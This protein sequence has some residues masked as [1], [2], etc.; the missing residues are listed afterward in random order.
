M[1]QANLQEIDIAVRKGGRKIRN[2]RYS[3]DTTLFAESKEALLQLVTNVKEK[4]A[5]AGVYLNLKK[6]TVTSTEEIEEFKL[7]GE[8]VE[9]V[10]D[11]VF[12]GAKIEDSG[13]CKGELL[14]R[15]A[16][17]RSAMTGLNKIWKDKDITITTTC[18]MVN[19]L[20]S[21]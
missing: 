3:D 21:Q 20:V 1:R 13:S 18:R 9:I 15:L 12:L 19:A 17:G 6:T 16:L 10:R 14:R 8:D 7:D 5:Q 4:S 11:F 2:L